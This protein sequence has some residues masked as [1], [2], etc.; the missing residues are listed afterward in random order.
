[1]QEAHKVI[2][3]LGHGDSRAGAGELGVEDVRVGVVVEEEQQTPLPEQVRVPRG[4]SFVLWPCQD[5][6]VARVLRQPTHSF[7]HKTNP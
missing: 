4:A 1:L 2:A 5:Y 7:A 3:A 6:G